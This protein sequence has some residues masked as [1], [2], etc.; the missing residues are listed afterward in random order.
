MSRGWVNYGYGQSSRVVTLPQFVRVLALAEG[1]QL[2]WEGRPVRR[3][4]LIHCVGSRQQSGVHEPQP[5]GEVNEYCSRVCCSGDAANCDEIR[6]RFPSV[7]VF[8]LYEDIRTYGRGQEAIYRR[9]RR[10]K[11][12]SCAS[13]RR[14]APDHGRGRRRTRALSRCA[15]TCA[16]G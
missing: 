14:D 12:A 2:E 8:D 7:H 4:A 6:Q 10:R 13:R 5:D 15:W 11:C 3:V 16:T 1:D 9:P